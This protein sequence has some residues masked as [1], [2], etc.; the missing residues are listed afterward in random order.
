MV[1]ALSA[2]LGYHVTLFLEETGI[3]CSRTVECGCSGARS[4]WS[5]H[6]QYL[7]S[8]FT[9]LRDGPSCLNK[10]VD[11]TGSKGNVLSNCFLCL[12]H[13]LS[14]AFFCHDIAIDIY[15]NSLK[16]CEVWRNHCLE[17][18]PTNNDIKSIKRRFPMYNIK[19]NECNSST[20]FHILDTIQISF[21]D[22]LCMIYC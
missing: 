8:I 5:T 3:V 17:Q 21:E 14:F 20:E 12:K 6:C 11:D 10:Q 4:F 16:C 15:L 19:T 1:G 22:V 13:W 7:G 2:T 18:V 9:F